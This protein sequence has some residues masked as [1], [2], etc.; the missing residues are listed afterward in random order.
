MHEYVIEGLKE[1]GF[2]PIILYFWKAHNRVSTYEDKGFLTIYLS[3]ST[4]RNRGFNPWFLWKLLF[5]VRS[6][7]INVMHVQRH[8]LMQYGALASWITGVPLIYTVRS[9]NILRNRK[10]KIVFRMLINNIS[11]IICVS[12]DVA[13]S[14]QESMELPHIE[15]IYN[16]INTKDYNVPSVNKE[17]ARGKYHLPKS[18]FIYGIVARLK[19]AKDHPTL[20]R[21][22]ATFCHLNN[23]NAYLAIVGDGPKEKALKQL[24]NELGINEKVLFL[25]RIEPNEVPIILKAFDVFVHPSF[26][27]GMPMAVLEAMSAGLPV[28]SNECPPIK[29]I[30]G[31]NGEY[32]II[33][34]SGDVQSMADALEKVYYMNNSKLSELGKVG[35]KRVIDSFSKEQMVEKTIKIY[36]EV[37]KSTEN[38][39]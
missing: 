10:R 37:I 23:P 35:R 31:P 8:R 22:F 17:Q 15:I 14:L 24:V 6:L 19:K 38:L 9:T 11:R 30:L 25:G 32:G 5:I 4:K 27:E 20:I 39:E 7:K 28:I 1:R 16:G 26:R 12:E 29:E 36:D 3:S 2:F 34:K 21:A 18:G 33:C 13:R